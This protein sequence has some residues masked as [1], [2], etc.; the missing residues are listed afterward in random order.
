MHMWGRMRLVVK[1]KASLFQECVK[2][3]LIGWVAEYCLEPVI[4]NF[5]GTSRYP[6]TFMSLADVS[7]VSKYDCFD[8]VRIAKHT[9]Q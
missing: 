5:L 8:D 2:M 9:R 1:M 3:V 4:M 7:C 6:T